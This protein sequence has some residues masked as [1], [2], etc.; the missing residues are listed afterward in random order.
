MTAPD[1]LSLVLLIGLAL[2]FSRM[3]PL[4][5]R[6]V[7]VDPLSAGDAPVSCGQLVTYSPADA[8]RDVYAHLRD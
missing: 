2:R 8:E 3:P 1:A 6:G 7:P 4:V 5:A